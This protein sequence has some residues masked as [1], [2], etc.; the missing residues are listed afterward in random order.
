MFDKLLNTSLIDITLI[1]EIK[2]DL[3]SRK[4]HMQGFHERYRFMHFISQ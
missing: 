4:F 2:L 1:A 3:S